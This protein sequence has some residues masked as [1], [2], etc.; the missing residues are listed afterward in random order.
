MLKR[1]Y[2]YKYFIQVLNW[3]YIMAVGRQKKIGGQKAKGPPAG[4]P[5]KPQG[6]QQPQLEASKTRLVTAK[7][8]RGRRILESKAPKVVSRHGTH[9]GVCL[10]SVPFLCTQSRLSALGV[11][12]HVQRAGMPPAVLE[13]QPTAHTHARTQLS[14]C[15]PPEWALVLLHINSAAC[16]CHPAGR[17]RQ[18]AARAVW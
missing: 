12:T 7:T 3:C 11:S 13:L 17:R 5:T 6:S 10:Q 2:N 1:L 8:R 4:K 15:T 16:A 9:G 18:E 14:S